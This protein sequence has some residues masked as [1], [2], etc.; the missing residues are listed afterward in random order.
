VIQSLVGE[1]EPGDFENEYRRELRAVLEAKLAGEEIARPEPV[2]EAPVVDLME[3]LRRSVDEAKQRKASPDGKAKGKA[4]A[5]AGSRAR[6][7]SA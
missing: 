6:A 2:E 1:W 7:K 5:T 4:K 3:A